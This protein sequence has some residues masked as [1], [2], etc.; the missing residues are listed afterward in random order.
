MIGNPERDDDVVVPHVF[1]RDDRDS[2]DYL[3]L[4]GFGLQTR[5]YTSTH[6]H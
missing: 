5:A 3:F 6:V 4:F 1:M 2:W